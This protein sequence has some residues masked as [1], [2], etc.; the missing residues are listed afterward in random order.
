MQNGL[1]VYPET[2]SCAPYLRSR[3]VEIL[4]V[5]LLRLRFRP[6]CSLDLGRNLPFL[7]KQLGVLIM[8]HLLNQ[9]NPEPG[10]LNPEPETHASFHRTT[11]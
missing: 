9:L 2:A 4:N 11:A 10:T 5:A 6:R 1:I 3:S 8:S 7:N